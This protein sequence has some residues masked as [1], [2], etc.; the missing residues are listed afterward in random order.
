MSTG[1][2]HAVR[3]D[4]SVPTP[5]HHEPDTKPAA[6]CTTSLRILQVTT[7]RDRRGSQVYAMD[8]ESGLRSLGCT[9]ETVA[10][11]PGEHGDG[12]PIDVFGP[13]R[14]S[15]STLGALRKRAKDY[16]V[17]IAH[18]STTLFACAVGLWGARCP[19]VYRQISDP[20]FW[21]AGPL[22][23]LRVAAFLRRAVHVVCLSR[24]VSEVFG[25]HYRLGP[26]S[27]TVIPNAVPGERFTPG[28]ALERAAVRRDHDVPAGSLVVLSIGALVEEKGVDLTIRSLADRD[29]VTLIVAGDGPDRAALEALAGKV[30]GDRARFLGPVDDP[31]PLYRSA[32]VL[33]MPT[34]GGDSMPAVLIEAGLCGLSAVTCPIGAITD[35]VIDGETGYVVAVDDLEGIRMATERILDNPELRARMG[36]RANIHCR[37]WFTIDSTAPVWAALCDRVRARSIGSQSAVTS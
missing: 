26:G 10:L 11:A 32:D 29:D 8:L 18:G 21:A 28:D 1:K 9:V 6:I 20:L 2:V 23:R 33:L 30:L 5:P 31:G 35:V 17:V 27:M 24:G 16:D 25:L 4:R 12:L 15:P 37:K 14:R 13:T 19:F 3:P 22:R 36:E 34:R 7:D